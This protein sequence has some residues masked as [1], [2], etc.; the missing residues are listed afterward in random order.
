[1]TTAGKVL[2]LSEVVDKARNAHSEG[3]RIVTTNGC[4]DILHRGHIEYL[5]AARSYGDL[6]FVG[7]NSD[8]SVKQNKGD[9]RPINREADRCRLLA[10]LTCVSFAFV[11]SGKD[12]VAFLK[13]IRPNI[14]VK[15]GDYSGRLIEQD[16][17]E[18]FGGEVKI[19]RFVA[20]YS[21]TDIIQKLSSVSFG[22]NPS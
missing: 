12:P 21:T 7:V 4:F 19:V 15:G 6:L 9:S 5:E 2:T 22:G 10:A 16:V 17:V 20:G 3:K 1:M 14:H 8:S 13:E 18:S 11:F